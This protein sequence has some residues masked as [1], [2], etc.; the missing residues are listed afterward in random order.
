[1]SGNFGS[2]DL[3]MGVSFSLYNKASGP[4]DQIRQSM[5]S[6][7]KTVGR[8]SNSIT[9]SAQNIVS[10]A[11]SVAATA[12]LMIGPFVKGIQMA[13]KFEQALSAAFARGGADNLAQLDLLRKEALKISEE[14]TFGAQEVAD[15]YIVLAQAG[16]KNL[17]ILNQIRPVTLLAAAGDI[18][19]A[20]AAEYAGNA[21]HQFNMTSED[22]GH[23]A[24]V[25][26]GG[27]NESAQS[28]E[29]LNQGLKYLGPT[30]KSLN[31][32]LEETVAYTQLV[33]NAGMKGS[34]GARA[35]GSSLLNLTGAS[36][37]AAK[38]MA[39]IGIDPFSGP[40]RT[41]VGL[42]NLVKQLSRAFKGLTQEQRLKSIAQIFGKDASQ[43]IS[44]LLLENIQI[45]KNGEKVYM[46]AGD[47][48]EYFTKKN[49]ESAGLAQRTMDIMKDN[50][51]GWTD[52]VKAMFK[53]L[54]INIGET[55]QESIKSIGPWLMKVLGGINKIIKSPF[56]AWM[57]KTAFIVGM[58]TTALVAFSFVVVTLIPSIWGLVT[59]AGA[60]LIEFAPIIAILTAI[61]YAIFKVVQGMESFDNA[62]LNA[63]GNFEKPLTAWEK[64]AGVMAG[65]GEIWKTWDGT[66]FKISADLH[67]KLAEAGVLDETLAM[68]T[69]LVRAQEFSKGFIDTFKL[70]EWSAVG[71]ALMA[72]GDAIKNILLQLGLGPASGTIQWWKQFGKDLGSVFSTYLV[73]TL[74]AT[75]LV[76]ESLFNGLSLLIA[77]LVEFKRNGIYNFNTKEW[78]SWDR[79]MDNAFNGGKP[80]KTAAKASIT[81]QEEA[82][83]KMVLNNDYSAKS[84]GDYIAGAGTSV[85][86]GYFGK[87]NGGS[88]TTVIEVPVEINLDGDKM[89]KAIKKKY[90]TEFERQQGH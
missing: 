19:L 84:I 72:V 4:A 2:G 28:L 73:N 78:F 62:S 52:R 63:A 27:A 13:N 86:D 1:M 5:V 47:A 85:M 11:I 9:Q 58:V 24:D 77:T 80:S 90:I 59:A 46:S 66:T 89:G 34:I 55:F 49:F 33:A 15:T 18:S 42:S 87:S 31:M 25:L 48:L 67:D 45:V 56:G 10:G 50:A 53:T 30:A 82:A 22:F 26:V 51:Q 54:M 83:K 64:M 14:T 7:E 71:D 68:G 41:F 61:G 12:A 35:F 36:S 3:G 37:K 69:Y 60:L 6:L 8:V 38:A 43:E 39:E 75:A 81:P 20:K 17:Q 65:L 23:I 79:V 21:M 57:L 32:S 70:A 40:G 88:K 44:T 16:F 29:N 74:K 76:F